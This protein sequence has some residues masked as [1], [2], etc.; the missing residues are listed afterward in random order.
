MTQ[1]MTLA[2]KPQIGC[3]TMITGYIVTTRHGHYE[4]VTTLKEAERVAKFHMDGYVNGTGA[5]N[6]PMPKIQKV[7]YEVVRSYE[8]DVCT[9]SYKRM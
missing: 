3:D 7:R 9:N 1:P 4:T 5:A 6:D 8:Y 2:N